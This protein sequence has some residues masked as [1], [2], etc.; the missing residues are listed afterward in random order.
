MFKVTIKGNLDF[1]SPRTY[2]TMLRQLRQRIENLY[3]NDTFF[4]EEVFASEL[5]SEA[6]ASILMPRQILTLPERTWRNS[7]GALQNAAE[8]AIAGKL[9]FW[10]SSQENKLLHSFVIEP[11]SEK[12]AVTAFR[13][14][15]ALMKEEGKEME[16]LQA[17][18]EAIAK[19][20]KNARAYL[21][22]G[23]VCLRL[24][25]FQEAEQAFSTS[26]ECFATPQAFWGRAHV[27]LSEK[28]LQG[29]ILDF[30]ATHEN[31]VP[32]QP[33]YWM[34]K[35]AK[36]EAFIKLGDWDNAFN[37]LRFVVKREFASSDPNFSLR[38]HTFKLFAQVLKAQGKLQEAAKCLKDVQ[39]IQQEEADVE[40]L[41]RKLM[42]EVEVED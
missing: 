11:S 1:G 39:T 28:D 32:L 29:A 31:A 36:G 40:V 8:F 10:V 33:I 25:R 16:A 14:G 24:E 38:R 6:R 22:R 34:A 37:E 17:I 42:N 20:Q 30:T 15:H 21:C 35:R 23:W 2:E 41:L 26:I 3:R 18:D 13:K 27:R 5:F 4:R 12:T 9:E 7:L 19:Y